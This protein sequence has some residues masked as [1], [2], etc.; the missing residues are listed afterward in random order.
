[1]G[2]DVTDLDDGRGVFLFGHGVVTGYQ[3]VEAHNRHLSQPEE[4]LKRYR[5]FFSDW[6]AVTEFTDVASS[7]VQE[8]AKMCVNA[9]RQN[10]TAIIAAS[11][12]LDLVYEYARMFQVL[13]S[14]TTWEVEVFRARDKAEGWLKKKVH[15]RFGIPEPTMTLTERIV[16]L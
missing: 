12:G 2:V 6:S 16:A 10:K 15:E 11:A 4:K 13:V 8:L 1:M 5:Y 14:E 7:D 9:S 3:F